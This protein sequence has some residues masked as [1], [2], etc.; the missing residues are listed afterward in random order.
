M[1]DQK[2]NRGK[3]VRRRV[4]IVGCGW[5]AGSQMERGFDHLRDRFEVVACC[6]TELARAR[7]FAARHGIAAAI[8]DF[9]ALLDDDRIDVVSIC[10]PPS[11]HHPM[12]MGGLAAGKH[13]ICEK[14]FTSSLRLMDE[15]IA[16]EAVSG[17]RVMP[18]FQYRFADGIARVRHL[19]R[20]GLG[21]RAYLSSVETA[22]LRGAD[23]YAVPWR[24]RFATELG[25][26]L[27]TQSIHIHD[28]FLWLMGPAA[29]VKGFKTTRVNP[30]EVE[31]CAVASLRMA[32]GSLAALAATLGS[33]RPATRIRLCF[34]NFVMER[35]CYD[36]DAP[37][38]G[39][40]PWTVV[41]RTPELQAE[42]ERILAEAPLGPV[43]FAGQFSDF[44]QALDA[45]RPFAVTLQDAR[46]SLELV[47][48]LFHAAETGETCTL[49]IG[50]DHA[51]YDG[52]APH[53]A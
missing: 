8:A 38:P 27:L 11:L 40:E 45:D 3:P 49:P 34:E 21:G 32:D 14:P 5:V 16:A 53:H 4:G 2:H 24:G 10:T 51:R 42:A 26:V 50:E 43:D 39:A 17:R 31:D 18:I 25:G 20:S 36:A 23:Y 28:L 12:V 29:E 6:D 46:R 33:V 48:A 30:I 1:N 52:W 9:Q 15:I 44:A 35:Q 22:W 37:K 47:T 19:I 7:D 13:V 41:A